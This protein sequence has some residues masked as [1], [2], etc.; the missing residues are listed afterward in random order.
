MPSLQQ[1]NERVKRSIEVMKAMMKIR[2]YI[3]QNNYEIEEHPYSNEGPVHLM[4]FRDHEH[5]NAVLSS[6]IPFNCSTG[7]CTAGIKDIS[8]FLEEHHPD[9]LLLIT[10]S[11]SA[12]ASLKISAST[13]YS[14]VMSYDDFV[15]NKSN[16]IMVPKYRILD[17]PEILAIEKKFG[18]RT[19]YPAIIA[20]TD[21]M[22]RFRDFRQGQ[23]VEV[24]S[25][26]PVSGETVIYKQIIQQQDVL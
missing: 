14:E 9:H 12:A 4:R 3:S 13:R 11:I 2:G 6:W 21:A 10:D 20:R 22:A 23:T 5:N 26:S 24:T 25:V 7:K 18:P 17:N 1:H 8:K 15:M 19:N 16:N